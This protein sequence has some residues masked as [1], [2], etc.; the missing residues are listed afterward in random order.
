MVD[1]DEDILLA[2]RLLV[3]KQ[4]AV[5]RTESNPRQ[6]PE[7][8]QKE[9]YDL[10]FLDMN[11][12]QDVTSG[13]EGMQWLKKILAI[14][15]C[16]V[17]ILITAYGDVEMAVRAVKEGA[18]DFILKPWQNEKLLTTISASLALRRSRLEARHLREQQRQLSAD[19]DQPF[20]DIIGQGAAIKHLFATV[21]K[22]A[23]TEANV[24]ILGENGT[25]KELVARAIH[26]QSN[27]SEKVFI[28]VDMGAITETLFES[29]LFGYVRGAFTDARKDHAGRFEVADGGTL[30]LDEIGNLP[31]ALQAKLL[32]V[33][34][35]RHITRVGSTKSQFVDIRLICA[36]NM[37]VQEMIT[38]GRFRQDLLY[39][40]NTVEINLPPLRE[41]TEDIP[42]LV[43]HFIRSF[44]KK[45]QKKI[46]GCSTE[47]ILKLQHYHWP[48]NI[49]EL[50]HTIERA[51]ILG[52]SDYLLTDDFPFQVQQASAEDS[53]STRYSLG[54]AE[55]KMIMDV[56][57]NCH[58]NV[59]QAARTLG[60]SR[61]ALYRRMER[62]KL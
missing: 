20:L 17:V 19:I 25:G 11:Y 1:D 59:S 35:S 3:Q 45:Y 49:R 5:V 51:I 29:E 38:D 9:S 27:R 28:S 13:Q 33:L 46:A 54:E 21:S 2:F 44:S 24:L 52:D 32:S 12:E 39:R 31:P 47:T 41:R 43:D 16:A 50:Q 42:L 57:K 14:D 4:V 62:H 18:V 53:Q 22:V 37:P 60:I 58:G 26:R 23:K 56:L 10:I 48:G 6:I 40:I 61:A 7:L 55:K 36:T 34:E 15:P 30:F 8:L